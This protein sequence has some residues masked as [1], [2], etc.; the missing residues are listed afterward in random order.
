MYLS[1]YV[2]G[3]YDVSIS[4]AGSVIAFGAMFDKD[5]N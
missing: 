4:E 3:F 5:Y 1:Q 2:P